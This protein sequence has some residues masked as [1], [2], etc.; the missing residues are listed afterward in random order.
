MTKKKVKKL[1][2]GE[3]LEQPTEE[4]PTEPVQTKR[5]KAPAL[6]ISDEA[7][8]DALGTAGGEAKI[9]PLHEAFDKTTYADVP[10]PRLKTA[11]RKKGLE[12]AKVGKVQAVH[13]EGKRVYIFKVVE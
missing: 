5:A 12:L 6:T 2:V 7:F 13:V 8:L 1:D 3:L 9:T 11:I 4:T 10:A